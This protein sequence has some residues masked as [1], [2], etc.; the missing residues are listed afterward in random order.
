[1]HTEGDGKKVL[2]LFMRPVEKALRELKADIRLA[3]CQHLHFT[4]ARTS[5]ATDVLQAPQQISIFQ[6][7]NYKLGK[8]L[9]QCQLCSTSMAHISRTGH[10]WRL[11]GSDKIVCTTVCVQWG[12]PFKAPAHAEVKAFL[13]DRDRQIAAIG[14]LMCAN[15]CTRFAR[16]AQCKPKQ[17]FCHK[18]SKP[19]ND[20]CK[21]CAN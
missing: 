18:L 4:S 20:Q 19:K 21:P 12:K 15:H 9:F 1:M 13:K 11:G 3:G 2:E 7:A 16:Y 6:L 14:R 17:L 5:V 10:G 8:A